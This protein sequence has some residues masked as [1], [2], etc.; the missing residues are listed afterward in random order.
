M[1]NATPWQAL[2]CWASGS[3]VQ[4]SLSTRQPTRGTRGRGDDK[5]T[6]RSGPE[7]FARRRTG[8]G[9][10][11]SQEEEGEGRK[12]M[13]STACTWNLPGPRRPPLHNRLLDTGITLKHKY[14]VDTQA[15]MYI[16]GTPS[17]ATLLLDWRRD[18]LRETLY[19]DG[20]P[21][22]PMEPFPNKSSPSTNLAGFITVCYYMSPT[23]PAATTT[24]ICS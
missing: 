9:R 5:H 14:S 24:T 6:L 22:R 20:S 23:Y 16:L 21:S 18:S 4:W 12:K 2:P 10:K 3:L 11:N 1:K 13:G 15:G 8:R 7:P 17:T 19:C